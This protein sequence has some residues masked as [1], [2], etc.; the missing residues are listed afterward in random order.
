MI[1]VADGW[2]MGAP[3]TT[4]HP[5][6]PTLGLVLLCAALDTMETSLRSAG[7]P[8]CPAP[9]PAALRERWMFD[10]NSTAGRRCLVRFAQ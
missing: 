6:A 1:W 5:L 10:L 7:A 3:A 2:F 4:G 9:V 8:S